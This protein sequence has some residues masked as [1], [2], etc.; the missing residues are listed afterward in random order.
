MALYR[1]ERNDVVAD[2][3]EG[4]DV[5]LGAHWVKVEDANP[6]PAVKRKANTKTE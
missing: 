5:E 1:N 3:P 6:S 4:H 2:L